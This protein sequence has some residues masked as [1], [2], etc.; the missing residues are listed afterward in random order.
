[1]KYNIKHIL[2]DI[3]RLFRRKNKYYFRMFVFYTLFTIF[4]IFSNTLIL[5]NSSNDNI[6]KSINTI[7]TSMLQQVK[8]YADSLVINKVY[9]LVN[10]EFLTNDTFLMSFFN[11]TAEQNP[12]S[13]Y[14]TYQYLTGL[15]TTDS[16][17]DSIS[18]HSVKSGI[19][20]SSYSGVAYSNKTDVHGLLNRA[21]ETNSDMMWISPYDNMKIY[22]M[23]KPV[24]S[25]VRTIPINM[26]SEQATGYVVINI[27]PQK[28]LYPVE[29]NE[30]GQNINDV[31]VLDETGKIL[32]S[33]NSNRI[34]N[35]I[36]ISP[37]YFSVMSSNSG[38]AQVKDIVLRWDKSYYTGF[39][40]VFLTQLDAINS[41][42]NEMKRN[43]ICVSLLLIIFTIVGSGVITTW[44]YQPIKWLISNIKN[45][46]DNTGD[47][48][49]YIDN[50]I[51]RLN[52]KLGDV[53]K[54]FDENISYIQ[55]RLTSE[56]LCGDISSK[57]VAYEKLSLINKD[58]KCDLNCVV[59]VE[60]G[61][62]MVKLEKNNTSSTYA[63]KQEYII[64]KVADVIQHSFPEQR[65]VFMINGNNHI[66]SIVN[67]ASE[68]ELDNMLTELENALNKIIGNQNY[69]IFV[70]DCSKNIY[71]L[72]DSFEFVSVCL[73]YSFIYGYGNRF[74]HNE[75]RKFE[76]N[77]YELSSNNL[78]DIETMLKTGHFNTFKALIYEHIT[79]LKLKGCSY[80]YVQGWL[81]SLLHTVCSVAKENYN[82]DKMN[83]KQVFKEFSEI[84]T[85]DDCY[86]RL[87]EISDEIEN[88]YL[89][90]NNTINDDYINRIIDYINENINKDISLSSVAKHI[91]MSDS[92]LS[93]LFKGTM[94][95]NF[96]TYVLDK[97]L[98][99]AASLLVENPQMSIANIADSIGYFNLSYFANL[100]KKKFGLTPSQYRKKHLD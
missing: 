37:E 70:G 79:E 96:S 12:I 59:V 73:K 68:A 82:Y 48:I 71:E 76:N 36:V 89:T 35:D 78:H 32:A 34:M 81:N 30:Q 25:F 60:L 61:K 90:R 80:H 93:K 17:I 67:Y 66:I 57:T 4:I 98:E 8:E 31:M 28:L 46:N 55:S 29:K 52:I 53:E 21:Q 86:I 56:L 77:D 7:Q 99:K 72:S 42:S 27:D 3:K 83:K 50:V 18:L 40:Y 100:F 63:K 88:L 20:V 91:G 44:I 23:E 92:Y 22:G 51:K 24:I 14:K 75:I 26:P 19:S 9:S 84:L 97:K 39:N 62:V 16:F 49:L 54:V 45:G 41:N 69:N 2:F 38:F 43:A 65:Y 5:F 74:T 95:M 10:K 85:L 47:E 6:K 94:G 87:S 33:I 58:F 1:M 64:W 15:V 11:E 13:L